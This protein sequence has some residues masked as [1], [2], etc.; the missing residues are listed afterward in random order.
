MFAALGSVNAV[1]DVMVA[2]TVVSALRMRS[3][4]WLLRG[5]IFP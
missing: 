1:F 4:D 2:D 5:M 3:S